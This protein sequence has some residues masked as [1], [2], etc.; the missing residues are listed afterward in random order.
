MDIKYTVEELL[1]DETFLDYCKNKD[2]VYKEKWEEIIS[3]YPDQLKLIE[4]ARAF[5]FLLNTGLPA[6]EVGEEIKKTRELILANKKTEPLGEKFYENPKGKLETRKFK[7]ILVLGIPIVIIGIAIFYFVNNR[8]EN[9][10]IEASRY[11]TAR[12]ERKTVTLPDGSS[13]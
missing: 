3:R 7:R 2:S 5:F 4:E 9:K 11:E 8:K 10:W 6:H 13:V 1:L 12:A